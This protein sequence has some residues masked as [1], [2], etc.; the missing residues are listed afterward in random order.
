M[1]KEFLVRVDCFEGFEY[2]G[3]GI[4]KARKSIAGFIKELYSAI[5]KD[6]RKML[7]GS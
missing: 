7:F 1:K 3:E 4:Q 5:Y 2:T 6:S